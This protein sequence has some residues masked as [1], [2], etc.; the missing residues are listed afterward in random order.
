MRSLSFTAARPGHTR[1]L[2]STAMNLF[3]Q[4]YILIILQYNIYN[5]IETISIAVDVAIT[6]LKYS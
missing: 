4:N 3:K 5:I 6:I 2:Q 1:R